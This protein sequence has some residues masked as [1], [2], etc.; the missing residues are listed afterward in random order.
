MFPRG[1]G[2]KEEEEEGREK[3]G[4]AW[5]GAQPEFQTQRRSQGAPAVHGPL[6]SRNLLWARAFP[7]VD[8]GNH[9]KHVW[10]YL[11]F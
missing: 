6:I 7:T 9:S 2:Q 5:P 11:T 4:A 10:L 1:E 8:L 3:D